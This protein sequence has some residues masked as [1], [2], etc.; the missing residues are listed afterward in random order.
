MFGTVR[1]KKPD[2]PSD[3]GVT[4]GIRLKAFNE[5]LRESKG[6]E[7]NDKELWRSRQERCRN[8]PLLFLVLLHEMSRVQKLESVLEGFATLGEVRGNR[9]CLE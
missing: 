8:V 7:A 3:V 2:E 5:L 1:C 4:A 9:T 6:E